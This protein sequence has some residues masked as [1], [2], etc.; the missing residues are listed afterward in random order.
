MI[1]T[2][3]PSAVRV[4]VAA[5]RID[6][7]PRGRP[8]VGHRLMPAGLDQQGIGVAAAVLVNVER[9]CVAVVHAAGAGRVAPAGD[10]IVS[11]KILVDAT[12][13]VVVPERSIDR[14]APLIDGD[15]FGN[16]WTPAVL[17]IVEIMLSAS[18]SWSTLR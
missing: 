12:A 2:S 5:C 18:P 1:S 6:A 14:V 8:A 7:S 11:A 3:T 4:S 13:K 16:R 17:F 10:A 9:R 15:L